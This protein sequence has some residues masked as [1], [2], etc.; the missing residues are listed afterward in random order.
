[1]LL[2]VSPMWPFRTV[3]TVK[4]H[5]PFTHTLHI[6]S[7]PFSWYDE[8]ET[9]L[10]R[11]ASENSS[12]FSQR[13]VKSL[14]LSGLAASGKSSG[15][16]V[17]NPH[18]FCSHITVTRYHRLP[19]TFNFCLVSPSFRTGSLCYGTRGQTVPPLCSWN[20]CSY[21]PWEKCHY[22]SVRVTDICACR[23][24]TLRNTVNTRTTSPR[25]D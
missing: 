24:V 16:S 5:V 15:A 14:S 1:M 10:I 25:L 8:H 6:T 9:F 21:F 18:C 17:W 13:V 22:I 2:T 11:A 4:M 12:T 19:R 3:S 7:S 23:L 20:K